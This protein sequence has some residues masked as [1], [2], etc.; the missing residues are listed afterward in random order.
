MQNYKL[1]IKKMKIS[2]IF[3]FKFCVVVLL[4]ALCTLHLSEAHAQEMKSDN[5]TIQGGNF[6]MTSG[7]KSSAGFKLSDVV[8]QTSAIIF[9]SKGYIVQS[10]FLN[11]AAGEVFLFTVSPTVVNFGTIYPNNF[12]ERKVKLTVG[13]GN[14]NGYIVTVIENQPLSTSVEA[15]IPDTGCD[16]ASGYICTISAANRWTD[17]VSYGLGYRMSG[18]TVPKDFSGANFF[19]PFASLARNEKSVRIMQSEIRKAMDTAAMTLKLNIDR[20]QPVGLYRNIIQFTAIAG[21]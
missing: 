4:F 16:G 17:P 8:G 1:K 7:N 2:K 3:L 12:S 5:Y 20:Q 10:G 6:N 9:T 15:Q 11:G 18:K 13:N 21:I 19:R 14:T